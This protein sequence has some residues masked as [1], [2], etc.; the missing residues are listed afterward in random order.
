M[1]AAADIDEAIN[2]VV[3]NTVLR[4]SAGTLNASYV[5]WLN[6][7]GENLPTSGPPFFPFAESSLENRVA[8]NWQFDSNILLAG[9]PADPDTTFVDA[10]RTADNLFRMLNAVR[11][12]Q[13]DGDITV[14]Q[15]D[16]IV[17]Q[18][19]LAWA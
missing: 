9:L 2:L 17:S 7:F 13:I 1:P 10:S 3:T 6:V 14:A 15:R 4:Q 11:T 16:A 18:Y 5:L 19:N 12:A 8:R